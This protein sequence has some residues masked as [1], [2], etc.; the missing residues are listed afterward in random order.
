MLRAQFV[1]QQSGRL[2]DDLAGLDFLQTL[3][4]F[5]FPRR[6]DALTLFA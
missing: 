2:A 5:R 3:C 4:R 6:L 1:E